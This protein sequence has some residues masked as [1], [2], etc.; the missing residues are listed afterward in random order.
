MDKITIFEDFYVQ[1]Y[2]RQDSLKNFPVTKN[3]NA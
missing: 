1:Y 3:H 2:G